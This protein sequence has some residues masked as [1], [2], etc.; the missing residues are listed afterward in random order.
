MM[1][2][3]PP[4]MKRM[5]RRIFDLLTLPARRCEKI[6][7]PASMVHMKMENMK[8]P[9]VLSKMQVVRPREKIWE[10]RRRSKRRSICKWLESWSLSDSRP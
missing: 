3:Q 6:A 7:D 10:S 2:R 8:R 4:T 5:L 1:L 9:M